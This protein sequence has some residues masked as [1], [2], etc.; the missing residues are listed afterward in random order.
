M[1][2][3]DFYDRAGQPITVEEWGRLFHD[4]TYKRVAMTDVCEGVYVSTVWLGL[5]HRLTWDHPAPV[6]FES[7][8]FVERAAPMVPPVGTFAFEGGECRRY[9]TE[10][11]A[12]AGHDQF[13]AELRAQFVT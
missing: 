6:I 5:D 4:P 13:V 2:V 7:M 3:P 9:C 8:V 12:I 1:R 11:Q 10:A